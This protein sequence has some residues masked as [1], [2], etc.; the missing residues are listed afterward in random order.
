M[1]LLALPGDNYSR[2]MELTLQQRRMLPILYSLPYAVAESLEVI[3][4]RARWAPAN[5]WLT[6]SGPLRWSAFPHQLMAE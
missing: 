4:T 6:S 1:I 3:H 2:P 5:G